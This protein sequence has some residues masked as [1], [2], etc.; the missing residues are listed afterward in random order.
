M[1][2]GWGQGDIFNNKSRIKKYVQ[3]FKNNGLCDWYSYSLAYR[4]VVQF[5]IFYFFDCKR[6][7]YKRVGMGILALP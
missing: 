5:G 3:F 7:D 2:G 1:I 6:L 4:L